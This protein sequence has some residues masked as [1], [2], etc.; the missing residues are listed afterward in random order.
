MV[1]FFGLFEPES[2]F[3]KSLYQNFIGD[4]QIQAGPGFGPIFVFS[5]KALIEHCKTPKPTFGITPVG[6]VYRKPTFI[7]VP[8]FPLRFLKFAVFK[9]TPWLALFK[10]DASIPFL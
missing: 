6:A 7:T 2:G 9:R 4:I 8:G 5:L 1:T 3:S 10:N